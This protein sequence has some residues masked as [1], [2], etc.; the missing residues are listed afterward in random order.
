MSAS[1]GVVILAAG[2]G[3]RMRSELTKVLHPVAGKPMLLWS[4]DQATALGVA[5]LVL[6]VGK[7]GAA[8]RDHVGDRADY[9]V[10]SERLGTGH[11][12]LQAAPILAGRSDVVL[13]LYGDMPTLRLE[14]LQRLLALHEETSAAVTLLAVRSQ[15]S[16]GFGRIVRDVKA[17]SRRSSRR[18]WPAPRCWR[19]AN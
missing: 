10:Q 3:T 5:R 6:V 7:D 1:L 11:A 9:A 15:D 17:T 13:S 2:E 18:L 8:V 12:L 14:T 16:M 4:V 19:S